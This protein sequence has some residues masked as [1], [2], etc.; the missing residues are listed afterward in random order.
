VWQ[1]AV[2]HGCVVGARYKSL[3]VGYIGHTSC[4]KEQVPLFIG[5]TSC[6]TDTGGVHCVHWTHFCSLD[7]LRVWATLDTLPA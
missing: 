2:G 3:E 7:T 5:H 1:E 4:M 6:M